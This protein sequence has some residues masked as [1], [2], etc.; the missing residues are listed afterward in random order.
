MKKKKGRGDGQKE[1]TLAPTLMRIMSV[2]E[3][4]RKSQEEFRRKEISLTLKIG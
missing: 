4:K 2:T 3:E 1:P